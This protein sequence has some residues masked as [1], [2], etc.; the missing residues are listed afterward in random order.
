[1]KKLIDVLTAQIA[2]QLQRGKTN[3][4]R[5]ESFDNPIVYSS[6]CMA[7]EAKVDVLIAKLAKDKYEEFAAAERTDWDAAICFLHKG[8]NAAFS[9]TT[10]A[11]YQENS[12]IDFNNAITKW[13][14]ESA[15]IL[16]G[17]TTLVLLMGT[18]AATDVGGLADTS[19]V[20]SP[21]ELLNVLAADYSQWFVP[22][23]ER[24]SINTP[25]CRKAIHTLYK[26]LFSSVNVNVFTL[27]DFIDE[28]EAESYDTAQELINYICETLNRVWKVPSIIASRQVPKIQAL[29][30]GQQRSAKAIINA[31][32]FIERSEDI[33]TESKI[34]A[35]EKKF[36]KYAEKN[37]IEMNEPFPADDHLFSSFITFKECV[38]DY[39]CGRNIETNRSLLLKLDYA[40]IAEII[41]T[42]LDGTGP[43]DSP[44]PPVS[45]EPIDALSKIFLD[46]ADAFYEDK[47]LYPNTFTL[48]VERI[49]LSNCV[50]DQKEESFIPIASFLGGILEFF[51]GANIDYNG[52]LLSFVYDNNV[53]P[54]DFGNYSIIRDQIK[55]TGKWGDPCKIQFQLTASNGTVSERYEYKWVFSPYC[56]WPNAFLYLNNVLFRDG[57]DY[58]SLPTLVTCD[59]IQDYLGCESEDE[60]YA[61]LVQLRDTVLFDEHRKEIHKY[62]SDNDISGKYDLVSNDFK[63]FALQLTR[64]GLFNALEQ[65]RRVVKSFTGLMDCICKSFAALTDVQREKLPLL[66]NCF[67]ITSN[68]NIISNCDAGEMLVPAYNPVMLEKIDAKQL[69]I[70]AGFAELMKNKLMGYPEKNEAKT[71]SGFSQ[72]A[73]I[74]QG[75]DAVLKKAS[76]FIICQNMWEYY[77][78]YYSGQIDG[79]LLSGNSFGMSIVTD[80]DDA[81]AMLSATP[82]SN[83]IV[84]NVMDYVH[85]FPARADGLNISFIA[86]TDM[87]HIVS[88]IHSIAKSFDSSDIPA[89]LNVRIV[90]VNS[91]KNSA[92]YLRKWLDSYFN[93]ERTVKVNTF[94]KNITIHDASDTEHFDQLLKN[95]DLC[96]TYNVLTNTG[97]QFLQSS[98]SAVDRDQTKF[99]MTFIPD[100]IASTHGKSRKVN[101]SQFQFLASKN[102]TQAS[103]VVA[104]P[105]SIPSMYRVF[106]TLELQNAQEQIIEKAHECCKWVVCIDPAI[107]REM[108]EKHNSKIIG[109]TTGE[110][111]YGELNVTV[112]ARSDILKDIKS[113][114]KKRITEK[115]TNWDSARLQKAADYCVDVLS[116]HM[117]GSKIL[118]ALNP[119]DYEIHN[120]LAY[121]LSLQMLNL[122]TKNDA[123]IVR[124]LISLDSYKHWFADDNDNMRPDFMLIEIPKTDDNLDPNR[125]LH[126]SIKVIECKMGFRSESHII[127][128]KTQLEKGLRTMVEKWNSNDVGIMHRY[129]MN[130]LY[131][132]IIFSPLNLANTSNEY[133]VV[134]GKIYDI[135]SGK[136]EFDWSGDIFAFWLDSNSEE[137]DEYE[138]DSD[139]VST[140]ASSGVSVTNLKCHNCGQMFIQKML[141]PP[142]DRDASFAYNEVVSDSDPSMEDDQEQNE[143]S[144]GDDTPLSG[145]TIP[146]QALVFTPFILHLS[147]L[148]E[149]TRQDCLQWFG[150]HFQ[151]S[152]EDRTLVFESNHHLKWETVLDSV[153]TQFRQDKIIENSQIGSFHI[154]D[155]GRRVATALQN[156]LQSSYKTVVARLKSEDE[157]SSSAT[158]SSTSAESSSNAH[159]ATTNEQG[160]NNAG[161]NSKNPESQNESHVPFTIEEA[162]LLL[163]FLLVEKSQHKSRSESVEQ[164]S[165]A[166]RALAQKRGIEVEDS[167]RS[168]KGLLG[169]M[170][171]LESAFNGDEEDAS[172]IGTKVFHSVSIMYKQNNNEYV[173]RLKEIK[174]LLYGP[175]PET[176]NKRLSPKPLKDVRLLLGKD[177]KTNESY[178]WEFGNKELNNRH[179]LINGNSGCGKTYCIQTLLME[180]ALQ[181]VSS[182]VF[183]YTGG[184]ANSKLDPAFK[185]TLGNRIE[186]RIVK[187]KKIP[188]NPFIKHDI[189]IDDDLF[190]PEE[191]ADVADKIAEIFKSVYSLGDQQRSAVYSAVLNGLKKYGD[192]MSFSAMAQE[193]EELGTSYAKTVIS[194]IQTFIDYNPFAT[195]ENFT[196]SDIRD[197][198]GTVYVFQL[199]G[200]GRE[201]QVLLTE[202]LL[203]DIWSYCV[204]NGNET[205]PFILVLDEAQNLSHGEKSPSA[206]ILTEGRKFGLSGWYATQFMKP[207]LTDDE[208]QRLQQAGQKLYFCPPDDGI[209]TVAR[210][211][212]IST[213]GAKDWSEKL[214]KLKKGECVTCGSMIR[215][216]HWGKYPPRIIKVTSLQE[217]MNDD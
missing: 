158:A 208:I 162:I 87:Q 202:L 76:S 140:L 60:F 37:G 75:L 146:G 176:N 15:N 189:Q 206:K 99:P 127:K 52:E 126:I 167:Y 91:K 70:R 198:S 88:A 46:A 178:Y 196:W 27:S 42:K 34:R 28:L 125:D 112:S 9:L 153:I 147:T 72:L 20:I 5:I 157:S 2:N 117:D 141:L 31:V 6:V 92:T 98:D 210:N 200:Y 35:L 93:E 211:I 212:D 59:N 173:Q 53:D 122:T 168:P 85:T 51:N 156:D 26:A 175:Q 132:A 188:V 95:C 80:D 7:L 13:R 68:R 94:L 174:E 191:N 22:V 205:T 21:K 108:L 137:P 183:D 143:A 111:S 186:Q 43:V 185:E 106:K 64:H 14:N 190:V 169:R 192:H 187:A 179:L 128:A 29:S 38:I 118:K 154:T 110:G 55:C 115:F 23:L 129:W 116:R 149:T 209:M 4:I 165:I 180:A 33:P 170:K 142:E 104:Y 119:Y 109:F 150:E 152:E 159:Q 134:R 83:I 121:I 79:E 86:P 58:Y 89:T 144:I 36:N 215:N 138:I 97:I 57:G 148:F 105:D 30:K 114:L 17:Q 217:R 41:D 103:H 3:I 102:H 39:L 213:Q 216:G 24:N 82:M 124:S 107:D 1:M 197:S 19:F 48:S 11:T 113:M 8:K 166:L 77:G 32:K 84:R 44:K 195:E 182:V 90:C 155:F 207:Q 81:S 101:I 45:G 65:L 96:F 100:T 10:D 184:F 204:K 201:I 78:V 193:L 56:A 139:T 160:T 181:G 172:A 131:R 194:K 67:T 136:V 25:E 16:T 120:Y 203:W 50:E 135:L 62:F 123:F 47:K 73:S 49:T 130:Q 145:D 63:N 133:S 54:F 177:L 61:Q 164:A 151:I 71:V 171:S 66:L 199:M 163:D 74:T 214:K 69:F 18:E 12:Y 161:D 40:I